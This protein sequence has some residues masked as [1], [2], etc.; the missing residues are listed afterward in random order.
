VVWKTLPKGDLERGAF[1]D[2]LLDA[3]REMGKE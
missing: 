3:I 2:Q 1:Q